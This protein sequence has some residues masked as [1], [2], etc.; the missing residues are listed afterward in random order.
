MT[1]FCRL[2]G[3]AVAVKLDEAAVYRSRGGE[4][5]PVRR[6]RTI[7]KVV[8]SDYSLDDART[9]TT[10]GSGIAGPDHQDGVGQRVM[11]SRKR[12]TSLGENRTCRGQ[13]GRR[14]RARP[15]WIQPG[16]AIIR[17]IGAGLRSR[18]KGAESATRSDLMLIRS[19]ERGRKLFG[20]AT[21]HATGETYML[22][23]SGHWS[24]EG[25]HHPRGRT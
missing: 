17:G 4:I 18:K 15:I 23:C 20:R 1:V 11:I 14:Q 16:F 21:I 2:R 22:A 19:H 5:A 25:G 12:L 6:A 8:F 3:E 24:M 13:A 10:A 7:W 9:A